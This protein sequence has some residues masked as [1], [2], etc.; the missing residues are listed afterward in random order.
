MKTQLRRLLTR[1]FTSWWMPAA[2]C[3]SFLLLFVSCLIWEIETPG[4]LWYLEIARSTAGVGG[5]IA[6]CMLIGSMLWLAVKKQW[7]KLSASFG[8]LLL[9]GEAFLLL[10][11]LVGFALQDF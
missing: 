7:Q 1:Y 5:M 8:T 6:F 3:G 10:S 11:F 2:A 9:G 4:S